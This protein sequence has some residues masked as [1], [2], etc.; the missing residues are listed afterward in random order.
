MERP[1]EAPLIDRDLCHKR[2][3]THTHTH[4]GNLWDQH[5]SRLQVSVN[6]GG[7]ESLEVTCCTRLESTTV[8]FTN[9]TKHSRYRYQALCTHHTYN[10]DIKARAH[11]ERTMLTTDITL[12]DSQQ[13]VSKQLGSNYVFQIC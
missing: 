3:R 4:R 5:V 10:K 2:A 8:K 13:L 1:D 7:G 12:T 6:T 11:S 9:H